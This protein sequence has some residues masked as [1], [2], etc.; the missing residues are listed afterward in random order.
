MP[1][2]ADRLELVIRTRRDSKLREGTPPGGFGTHHSGAPEPSTV[3]S[4]G[5]RSARAV[6][7]SLATEDHVVI[8]YE[9]LV[10]KDNRLTGTEV[11]VL[12]RDAI[13]DGWSHAPFTYLIQSAR[14]VRTT[15]PVFWPVST[16][17]VASTTCSSG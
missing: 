6:A 9:G 12:K 5:R 7:A 2:A 8:G 10:N 3:C 4:G 14:T 15:F 1:F 16:Y 11:V 13:N 17:L